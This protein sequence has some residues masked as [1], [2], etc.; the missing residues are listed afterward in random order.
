MSLKKVLLTV[1]MMSIIP[2]IIIYDSLFYLMTRPS[3][4]NCGNLIEFLRN[5]SLTVLMISS[6]GYKLSGKKQ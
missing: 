1:L 2:F 6:V 4:L 3:C 5:S